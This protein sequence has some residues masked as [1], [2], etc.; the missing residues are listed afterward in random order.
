[1][2]EGVR[3]LGDG[4]ELVVRRGREDGDAALVFRDGGLVVDVRRFARGRE[5]RGDLVGAERAAD[6]AY[7]DARAPVARGRAAA[8]EHGRR[9]RAPGRRPRRLR[10]LG[11]AEG[12]LRGGLEEGGVPGRPGRAQ[13]AP[14]VR[15]GDGVERAAPPARRV[16]LEAHADL[17]RVA[18]VAR[19]TRDDLVA[20]EAVGPTVEFKVNLRD[21]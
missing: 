11:R 7:A 9:R 6:D 3:G 14:E 21:S 20:R 19:E 13:A 10:R 1:M 12:A 15:V 2:A 18:E 5:E 4:L 16:V 17:P 8:A